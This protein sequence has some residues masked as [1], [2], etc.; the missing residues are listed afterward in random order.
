MSVFPSGE[1]EKYAKKNKFITIRN[2]HSVKVSWYNHHLC[3]RR[4]AM[5]DS[6]SS[7][8]G[9]ECGQL[10]SG[11]RRLRVM[12][13]HLTLPNCQYE[14]GKMIWDDRIG[15]SNTYIEVNATQ[16]VPVHV[17]CEPFQ[18]TGTERALYEWLVRD[19]RELRESIFEFLKV[20]FG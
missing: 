20:R 16:A 11:N 9:G 4:K 1:P 7:R 13:T 5:D 10:E 8:R 15:G 3:G 18:R 17:A 12:A 6:S 19:N 2:I 14:G